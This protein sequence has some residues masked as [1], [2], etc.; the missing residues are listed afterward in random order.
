MEIVPNVL[1]P[2]VLGAMITYKPDFAVFSLLG[3]LGVGNPFR[4]VTQQKTRQSRSKMD[5]NR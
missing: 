5:G 1:G 3:Q 4:A 2:N